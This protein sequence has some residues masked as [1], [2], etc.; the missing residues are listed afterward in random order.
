MKSNTFSQKHTGLILL[1]VLLTGVALRAHRLNFQSLW[2]DEIITYE[3][4]SKPLASLLINPGDGNMPPLY[5][6]IIHVVLQLGN[7]EALRLPSLIFGSLSILLFYLVLQKWFGRY[8]SILCAIIMAIS[9]FHVWYSQEAR[10]YI[11]ILLFSLLSLYLTQCSIEEPKSIGLKINLGISVSALFYSHIVTVAFIG[12]LA[13]Y[14]LLH[15]PRQTWINWLPVM[16]GIALLVAPRIY[17][18]FIISPDVPADLSRSFN[19]IYIAYAIWTFVT[20]Y[21]LGP[22]ISELHMLD[23]INI[24][25]SYFPIIL[26]IMIF[27]FLFSL[28]GVIQIHRQNKMLLLSIVLWFILPLTFAILGSIYTVHP[29][30]VRYAIL[31]FPPFIAFL[32][33]GIHSL[34]SHWM[35]AGTF[36]ILGIISVLSLG[37]YY[38]NPRYHRD[39]IRSAGQYLSTHAQEHDVVIANAPY[40]VP[41]I[42]HY[43]HGEP[44]IRVRGYPPPSHRASPALLGKATSGFVHTSYVKPEQVQPDL[45]ALIGEQDRFWLFLSRTYHSDPKGYIRK[46]LDAKYC[47]G[48]PASWPG[49]ELILYHRKPLNQVC[50]DQS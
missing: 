37:N 4:S 3:S 10:P 49:A 40:T 28:L 47:R 7:Q 45:Q 22:T 13:I 33:I 23:H 14:V 11:M 17:Q 31:S 39:D 19:P 34:S 38:Y 1:C 18:Q 16:V 50:A 35:R 20:G 2:N 41:S 29:F 25:S 42:R 46:F 27:F 15:T 36:G 43:Y 30:N 8:I 32:T 48:L 9:P 12:F 6:S 5:Y 21:S 26:P 24:I 44:E